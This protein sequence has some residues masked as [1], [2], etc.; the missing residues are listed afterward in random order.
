MTNCISLLESTAGRL[1]E[2]IESQPGVRR[3]PTKD[4]GWENHRFIGPSFRLAHIELFNQDRF[5]VVHACVFPRA[6]DPAPIYGFDVIA[7]ESKITGVFM[8]LSP[9][10]GDPYPFTQ[11]D[12]GRSR[13]RPEWGQIFSPYWLACRPTYD[14]MMVISDEAVKVLETYLPTLG[15]VGDPLAIKDGQNRYCLN[16]QKNEHTR[17]ALVKLL[18]EQG[19]D[20]FMSDILFPT[21]KD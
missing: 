7:G 1:L 6:T 4:Y 9:T 12:I 13:D 8:D 10:A 16:Q 11:L 5:C 2:V 20:E 21:I 19:A 17:K 3:I 14:E 15:N 18:G